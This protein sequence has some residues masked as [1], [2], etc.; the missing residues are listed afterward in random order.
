MLSFAHAHA[1]QHIPLI[2]VHTLPLRCLQW[3]TKRNRRLTPSGFNFCDP[4]SSLWSRQRTAEQGPWKYLRSAARGGGSG[5]K[6]LAFNKQDN[7][8]HTPLLTPPLL[9]ISP[10]FSFSPPS[11]PLSPSASL[12]LAFSIKITFIVQEWGEKTEAVRERKQ[13]WWGGKGWWRW[14]RWWWGWSSNQQ[15]T[16]VRMFMGR[17][18]VSDWS[19]VSSAV[20]WVDLE[21]ALGIRPHLLMRRTA[22]RTNRGLRLRCGELAASWRSSWRIPLRERDEVWR[23]QKFKEVIKSWSPL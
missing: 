12:Y 21:W 14:W 5:G 22:R 10:S 17:V 1:N 4:S 7:G 20:A 16:G 13:S 9:A 19:S 15:L 18:S 2:H 23:R 6:K 3:V 11:F 8:C